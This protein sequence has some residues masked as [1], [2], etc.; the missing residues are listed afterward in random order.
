MKLY[1][2]NP[3]QEVVLLQCKYT[4]HKQ[5]VNIITSITSDDEFNFDIMEKAFNKVVERNDCLR[6]RFVKKDKKLM[7]Y[8]EESVEPI[9]VERLSF[10]NQKEQEK[11]VAKVRKKA[12]KYKKGKVIEPYFVKTFDGKFMVMLKVCHIILD[13]YGISMIYKDLL[14]VYNALKDGAELPVLPS[15]FEE[16]VIKDLKRKN[17]EERAKEN[18]EFFEK[19]LSDKE[20]PYYAGIHGDKLPLW[21]KRLAKGK[22][23]MK[24]F[25][26]KCDTEGYIKNVGCDNTSKIMEFCQNQKVSPA[27]FMFYTMSLCLS[28][29]NGDIKHMLPLELF[30]C[31]GTAYDKACAGTKVQSSACYTKVYKEKSFKENFEEFLSVQ[32]RLYRHINFSDQEFEMLLHKTYKSSLMETYYS[33]T[34]SFI[35]MSMPNGLVFD[36]YSNKKCSLPAYVALLYD[37]VTGDIRIAYDCQ[38]QIIN[39]GDVDT[40]HTN[41]LSI[42]N[43][44]I[45]NIDVKVEDIKLEIE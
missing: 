2:L 27:N 24:M 12:I 44:I 7:Q 13:M 28:K 11:F 15:K 26:I 20:E 4:L 21:Q 40:F 1:E 38:T 9:K 5:I 16:V 37:D 31:R 29:M 34:F 6:I 17:N 10:S 30:N 43:Q 3:S 32:S 8:F 41:Y 25:F 22:R 45:D 35:P 19:Y 18:R 33:L 42:I 23:G 39:E 36:I 14:E